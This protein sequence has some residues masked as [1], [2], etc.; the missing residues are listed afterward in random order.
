M[1]DLARPPGPDELYRYLASEADPVP[2]SRPIFQ[3]DV[4]W[5]EGLPGVTEQ[6]T[7][8]AVISHACTMR[9]QAGQLVE[10]LVMARVGDMS[11]RLDKY[12]TGH[13][14]KFPLPGLIGMSG[15]EIVLDEVGRVRSDALLLERR[16]ACLSDY[17]LATLQQRQVFVSTRHVVEAEVLHGVNSPALLEAELMEDWLDR[18][19]ARGVSINAATER[20]D[21]VFH[22]HRAGATD[23]TLH[24]RIRQLVRAAIYREYP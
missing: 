24:S 17:G 3:G 11:T 18:A 14:S 22:D 13:Y 16:I 21:E 2:A 10:H 6:E 9:G 8:A 7:L 15:R 19:M 12:E 4:L 23:V 5:I 20:F 1:G